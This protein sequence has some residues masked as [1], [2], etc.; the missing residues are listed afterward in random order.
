MNN[1]HRHSSN[2]HVTGYGLESAVRSSTRARLFCFNAKLIPALG[3]TQLSA[4]FVSGKRSYSPYMFISGTCGVII[5][6]I[7]ASQS[8]GLLGRGISPSQDRYL[9]TEQRKHRKNAHS[10]DVHASSRIRAHDPSVRASEDSS[11]L[12]PRGNCDRCLRC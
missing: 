7:M 5:I 10:T 3:F 8:V 11:C 12:R 9:H 6:I 4:P 1:T 2:I